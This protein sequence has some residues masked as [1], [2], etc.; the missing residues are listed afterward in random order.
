MLIIVGFGEEGKKVVAHHAILSF[1]VYVLYIIKGGGSWTE[2]IPPSYNLFDPA[3]SL[4]TAIYFFPL[5]SHCSLTPPP[6]LRLRR[7]LKPARTGEGWGGGGSNQGRTCPG[8]AFWSSSRQGDRSTVTPALEETA[9]SSGRG[10]GGTMICP[11]LM[12]VKLFFM[13]ARREGLKYN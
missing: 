5:P 2:N 3:A 7:E 11:P 1:C 6:S 10:R 13:L 9:P 12:L 8:S 4:P